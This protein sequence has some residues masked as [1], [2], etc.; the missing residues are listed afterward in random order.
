MLANLKMNFAAIAITGLIV[1]STITAPLT[2]MFGKNYNANKDYACCQND[3]LVL[4]HYYTVNILWVE[5]A[6]GYTEEKTGKIN[7]GGCDIRCN[8]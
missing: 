8:N 6:N 5:V 7:K 2:R 1:T 3:Q 4:H